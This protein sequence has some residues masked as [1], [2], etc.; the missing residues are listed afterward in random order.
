MTLLEVSQSVAIDLG[1]TDKQYN[2]W[3]D[4]EM[5]SFSVVLYCRKYVH[6]VC[7]PSAPLLTM[8]QVQAVDVRG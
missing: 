6:D 3:T 2:V 1:L 5:V 7:S 4:M 8:G